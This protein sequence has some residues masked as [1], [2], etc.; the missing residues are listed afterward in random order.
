MVTVRVP[1]LGESI[2]EVEVLRWLK[3]PGE[4]VAVDESL[5]ELGTDKTN[6][7]VP[8]PAAGV[9]TKVGPGPGTRLAIGAEL[10]TIDDG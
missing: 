5:V 2:F 10:A 4:T 7:M 6:F 3:Q 1:S 8:A 9:L